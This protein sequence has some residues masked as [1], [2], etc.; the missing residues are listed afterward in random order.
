VP[1]SHNTCSNLPSY[2]SQDSFFRSRMITTQE[3]ISLL[4][5]MIYTTAARQSQ[6]KQV[7]KLFPENTLALQTSTSSHPTGTLSNKQSVI[8]AFHILRLKL[9]LKKICSLLSWQAWQNKQYW[10]WPEYPQE[11]ILCLVTIASGY[12]NHKK[13]ECLGISNIFHLRKVVI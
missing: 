7:L 6:P 12:S 9:Q 2:V 4:P 3:S 5:Q 1:F 10:L 13:K 8:R 11:H